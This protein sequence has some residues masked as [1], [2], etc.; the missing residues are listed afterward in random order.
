MRNCMNS[1]R[2]GDIIELTAVLWLA[3][4]GYEV[5]TNFGSNGPIDLIAVDLET[6][7]TIL[8]DVKKASKY[9]L[10]DGTVKIALPTK[11]S[12]Q[13]RALQTKLG[14]KFLIVDADAEEYLWG[15]PYLDIEKPE[16]VA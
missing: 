10:A 16:K 14:V 15:Q 1:G 7:E 4:Q 2:S 12:T 3:K 13:A 11:R 9:T 6:G 8:I 5:F